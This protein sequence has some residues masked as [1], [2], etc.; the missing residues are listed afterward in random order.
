[1]LSL[2][3]NIL[4]CPYGLRIKCHS[5]LQVERQ[6]LRES[7]AH[8]PPGTLHHH[9]QGQDILAASGDRASVIGY[10]TAAL[11]ISRGIFSR[12]KKEYAENPTRN[13]SPQRAEGERE[14]ERWGRM[15][16]RRRRHRERDCIWHTRKK[17]QTTSAV[18]RRP[19]LLPLARECNL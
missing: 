5:P 7:V 17:S 6:L 8:Q 1:M 3:T 18:L 10:A 14:R 2:G 9:E 15:E 19:Y 4:H 13:Q 12:H 11:T 16:T